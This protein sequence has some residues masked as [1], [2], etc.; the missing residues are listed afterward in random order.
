MNKK[1]TDKL[2]LIGAGNDNDVPDA[3]GEPEV[4]VNQQI[5]DLE[6]RVDHLQQQLHEGL[7]NMQ[8]QNQGGVDVEPEDG[9]EDG[10]EE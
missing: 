2:A 1:I 7:A 6:A 5:H 9:N 8:I 3:V 10:N 4:D